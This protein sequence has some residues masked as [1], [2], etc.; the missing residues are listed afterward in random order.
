MPLLEPNQITI[1]VVER[2]QDIPEALSILGISKDSLTTPESDLMFGF[3]IEWT[4]YS[5]YNT[6]PISLIQISNTNT[7][8]VFRLSQMRKANKSNHTTFEL[9]QPLQDFLT[10]EKYK[11]VG[12]S[13]HSDSIKINK[14]FGIQVKG[15]IEISDLPVWNRCKPRSLQGLTAHFLRKHL[16]KSERMTDWETSRLSKEQIDYAALDAWVGLQVIALSCFSCLLKLIIFFQ[17]KRFI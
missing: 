4:P 11:K 2:K 13:T 14:E 16:P 17:T 12:L 8:V 7:S 15:C 3:D 5:N 1:R 9:P 6:K 10:N